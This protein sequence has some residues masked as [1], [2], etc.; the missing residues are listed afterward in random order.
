MGCCRVLECQGGEFV[1]EPRIEYESAPG[2]S[3]SLCSIGGPRDQIN[4]EHGGVG[5]GIFRFILHEGVV[6]QEVAVQDVRCL[7]KNSY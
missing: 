4:G 3:T 2:A 7:E 1:K 6:L 5:A